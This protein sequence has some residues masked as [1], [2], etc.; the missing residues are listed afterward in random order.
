MSR[1][2]GKWQR[3]ILAASAAHPGGFWL[4]SLLGEPY[5]LQP[6]AKWR[7]D[8]RKS[9]YNALIRSVLPVVEKRVV[10]LISC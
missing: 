1:G 8:Y 2:P 3:A 4:R 9:D 7:F 6:H 10:T 5:Q